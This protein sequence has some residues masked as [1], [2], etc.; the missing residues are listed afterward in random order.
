MSETIITV[1]ASV[2]NIYKDPDYDAPVLT[3]ALLGEN[4]GV[5][6]MRNKWIK[7][8][9]EDGYVGWINRSFIVVN[10][11][12][13]R[14][15]LICDDLKAMVYANLQFTLPLREIIYGNH[16]YGQKTDDYFEVILPD[17]SK[18]WTKCNFRENRQKA[19][20]ENLTQIAQKFI[21]IQ[22]LWGGKSVQGFDC[23]GLVQTIFQGIG[24]ILP[25]DA[26]DQST[27]FFESKIGPEEVQPGDLHFFGKDNISHV[28]IA[29]GRGKFIHSQGW[30]KEE[31]FQAASP[32]YNHYLKSIFL[33]SVSISKTLD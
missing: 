10:S 5:I 22:Y 7:I 19:S 16:V 17:G 12:K 26:S 31:S 9:L 15:N 1:N 23:S 11:K 6:E 20:R 3:Q 13:Y 25:R 2:A 28:A 27:Y 29:S 18:G 14:G 33:H 21:G 32:L 24:I 8:S 30:V 4:C